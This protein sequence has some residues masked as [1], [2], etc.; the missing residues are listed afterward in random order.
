MKK[1]SQQK[2]HTLTREEKNAEFIPTIFV[3]RSLYI[4][5]SSTELQPKRGTKKKA[6]TVEN[7]RCKTYHNRKAKINKRNICLWAII[8]VFFKQNMAVN[9]LTV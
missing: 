6:K 8:L 3:S 4:Y 2:L 5:I 7:I 9:K 1:L